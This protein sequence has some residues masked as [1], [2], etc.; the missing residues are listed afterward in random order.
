M[1]TD[2]IKLLYAYDD[3]AM[4]RILATCALLSAEQYVAPAS[5]TSLRGTLVHV[6]DAALAWRSGFEGYF[7]AADTPRES[8]PPAQPLDHIDLTEA[9][10]PTLAALKERWQAEEGAMR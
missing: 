6:L 10:V 8:L 1:K 2:E 5:E 3:W 4:Q 9:D 7:V